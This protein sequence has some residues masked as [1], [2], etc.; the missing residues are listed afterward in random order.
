VPLWCR[1]DSVTLITVM[2]ILLMMMIM[3]MT[4]IIIIIIMMMLSMTLWSLS[5]G[6][7]PVIQPVKQP[8]WDRPGIQVD[9]CLVESSLSSPLQRA[10]FLAASAQH[11]GEWLHA[12]PFSSCGLRLDDE[13]VRVAIG[14]RLGME[15]CVPHQCHCGT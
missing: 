8:F 6:A 3:M 13:A 10:T 12:L 2:L 11:R 7:I 9:R 1:C 14:L 5:F 15:L 4:I